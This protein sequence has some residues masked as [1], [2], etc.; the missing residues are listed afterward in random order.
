MAHKLGKLTNLLNPDFMNA[1]ANSSAQA[2]EIIWDTFKQ[3]I[4]GTNLISLTHRK[5]I[6]N[7][8][9]QSGFWV[10]PVIPTRASSLTALPHPPPEIPPLQSLH[11]QSFYV[12]QGQ[13]VEHN[14][15]IKQKI[16]SS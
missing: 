7:F 6:L 15:N 11:N 5:L 4:L 2:E 14:S 10:M 3:H 9:L 16:G 12:Q 13:A 1:N 8:K